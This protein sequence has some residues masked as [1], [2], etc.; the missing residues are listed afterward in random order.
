M[1]AAPVHHN[2]TVMVELTNGRRYL[3]PR[4]VVLNFFLADPLRA[5]LLIASVQALE[6]LEMLCP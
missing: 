6:S 4:E 3:L 5:S 1:E 2:T